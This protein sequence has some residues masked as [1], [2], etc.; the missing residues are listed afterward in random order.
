MR[1][2][3]LPGAK[4]LAH[5]PAKNQTRPNLASDYSDRLLVDEERDACEIRLRAERRAGQ[6]LKEIERAEGGGDHRSDHP[7]HDARGETPILARRGI[8]YTQSSRWQK[9]AEVYD[10]KFESALVGAE[11]PTTVGIVA[12]AS[13]E[14]P[15]RDDRA[16]AVGPPA[17]FRVQRPLGQRSSQNNR[18]AVA[19][20]ACGTVKNRQNLS[21]CEGR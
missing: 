1:L 7:S 8:S 2:V 20:F 3:N 9:L 12:S 11:M 13:E 15:R 5:R 4:V 18:D 19:A 6:L 17:R 10:D 14:R 21:C 16:V